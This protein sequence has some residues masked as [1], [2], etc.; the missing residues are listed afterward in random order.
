MPTPM[1]TDGSIVS[2]D[3]AIL[4]GGI[5][6]LWLLD[7]LRRDG[8]HV[9]LLEP[10]AL[11]SGQ[12]IAS[13]G[14]IHGGLKYAITGRGAASARAIRD[15]PD[16]WRSCLAGERSPDLRGT[17]KR[18]EFCYLWRTK[19]LRSRLGMAGARAGLR[20]TPHVI[21][22]H[23]RPPIL[24]NVPG[25]VARL[26]EQVIEPASMLTV[27][28][29]RHLSSILKIDWE[30]GIEMRASAPGVVDQVLLI[31]PETG[32]DLILEPRSVVLTAGG[33]NDALRTM[34]GLSTTLGQRRPLHMVMA[35]G[36]LPVLN[37]HCVDGNRTR[38]TITSTQDHANRTVWQI[39]GRI[40]ETGVDM[41]RD[42]LIREAIGELREV[43]PGFETEGTDWSTY[44]VDRAESQSH[45]SR[46]DD[47]FVHVDG[48]TITTWPTK[49]AL[50]PKLVDAVTAVLPAADRSAKDQRT[51][52]HWP[53]PAVAIPPW[54][55]RAPWTSFDSV[56]QHLN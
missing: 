21:A 41:D 6:G 53:R 36:A 34:V 2:L 1:T 31:N 29:D 39:G 25:M 47:V 16:I 33:G 44:R 54:E 43:L 46:P 11:G 15:M 42:E 27:M 19:S 5:A 45:G 24:S 37:G 38:I 28:S 13:Q 40:A 20:V 52:P 55:A 3:V 51:M 30:H 22:D 56:V 35:R 26:D 50:V 4:G 32:E 14:I 9:L 23:E 17:R 49:L 10:Y 48:R 12:T 7:T 18:A 8:Y